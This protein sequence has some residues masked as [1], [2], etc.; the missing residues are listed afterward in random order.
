[1]LPRVAPSLAR[2]LFRVGVLAVIACSL[3][4][5]PAAL[6]WSEKRVES[7][8][9]TI[10]LEA[11]GSAVIRHELVLAVRGAPFTRLTLRGVDADAV[12]LPDA[13]V[14]RLSGA[15]AVSSPEPVLVHA[16]DGQLDVS[17]RGPRGLRGRSFLLKVGYR[18]HLAASGAIRHLPGTERSELGWVGP[19][20][21]DGVD[22]VTV[23]LRTRAAATPPELAPD[24]GRGPSY[25][26]VMSTL[27]RSR[28]HDELELVRAHVARDEAIRWDIRLDRG[29]FALGGAAATGSPLAAPP[30]PLP[31]REA[32]ATDPRVYFGLVAAGALYALLVWLKSRSV[33]A[34]AA[35]RHCVP[36]PWV[37]WPAPWR[38]LVAGSAVSAAG[39]VAVAGL[40]P[41]L[42]A[43]ALLL[44]MACSASHA[45]RQSP[46]LR[47]PG[48]WRPL[49]HD[50]L[51]RS[52]ALPLPGA[53]LDAGR[54][55]GFLLLC[56]ALGGIGAL[57]A[58]V[59]GTSPYTGAC[60]LLGSSVLLPIFCT[61]RAAELPLDTLAHSRAFLGDVARRL[62][63]D[64]SL[65]VQPMGRIA[66]ANGELDE[67]RLSLAP[68]RPVP[69]LLG[70]EL[71]LELRERIGG[72]SVRPVVILRAA[73]GSECQR[74]LPR[75]VTWMRGRNANE[76]AS[77]I[78]PKLPSAAL[79]VA[80]IQ[81]LSA[82]MLAP[83]TPA[84]PASKNATRVGALPDLAPP[85]CI[86]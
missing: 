15:R 58:R 7:S 20:F 17:V 86:S 33:D 62:A 18:T 27:R 49:E 24:D 50:A 52:P 59:F 43:L 64:G 76:R 68:A 1:M 3:L 70:M 47:G 35:L 14:M 57:A 44:A 39:Y 72:H 5:S 55:R 29:L 30:P 34:A 61:G 4:W 83:P 80:L 45:P 69:G 21:D 12:P 81:E 75:G 40:P 48:E 63:R 65:L 56:V 23:I 32:R 37:R 73:E 10:E 67:L 51:R 85:A 8:T 84:R 9:T 71:G 13:T 28:D 25:G 11:D 2:V 46:S 38:A 41:W 22:A 19:R 60:L 42:G 82:L 78:R 54:A 53:W 66:A 16:Q 77:L 26:I 6:A 74:A 31:A 36:R 79:S